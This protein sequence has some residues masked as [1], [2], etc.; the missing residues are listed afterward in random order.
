[1]YFEDGTTYGELREGLSGA[2]KLPITHIILKPS[3]SYQKLNEPEYSNEIP[4]SIGTIKVETTIP[5]EDRITKG[6]SNISFNPH[7]AKKSNNKPPEIKPVTPEYNSL[8]PGWVIFSD[9]I[10]NNNIR[11][12]DVIDDEIHLGLSTLKKSKNYFV[13]F[14]D[15]KGIDVFRRFEGV[16]VGNDDNGHYF[17][18]IEYV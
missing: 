5:L 11:V 12:Y 9:D 6:M 16:Y 15:E 4:T 2:F 18:I 17:K 8:I 3:P 14:V 10:W 13:R 7:E 1:M